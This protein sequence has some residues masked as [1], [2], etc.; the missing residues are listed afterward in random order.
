[1]S[2]FL[3][4]IARSALL[5]TRVHEWAQPAGIDPHS[6]E[7]LYLVQ[8]AKRVAFSRAVGAF[9]LRAVLLWPWFLLVLLARWAD[10]AMAN[11]LVRSLINEHDLL[12]LAQQQREAGH[13]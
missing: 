13:P 3:T 11:T 4:R 1:M 10:L 2:A 5:R 12:R 8:Q 6:P 7:F 9:R